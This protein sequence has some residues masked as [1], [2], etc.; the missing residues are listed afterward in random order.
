MPDAVENFKQ[1]YHTLSRD[2]LSLDLLRSAYHEN[3]QFIDPLHNLHGTTQLLGYFRELYSNVE[4]C[5]FSFEHEII[6]D[7]QAVLFW[8]MSYRHPR[9]NQG[10][11][12]SVQG[13][14]LLRFDADG[15]Y[16][17]RDYIDMGAMLYEYIPLLGAVIR[18]L[19]RRM[20]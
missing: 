20:Q 5:Q 13:N 12:I 2:N 10:K 8:S 14:S 4:H 6:Q 1:L 7:E 18:W 19:K 3:I 9:L 11:T 15:V 17:H 16:F